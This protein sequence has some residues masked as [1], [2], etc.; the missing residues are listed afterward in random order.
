MRNGPFPLTALASLGLALV[1][2]WAGVLSLPEAAAA[3]LSLALAAWLSRRLSGFRR[4][5]LEL[6]LLPAAYVLT[7][8]READ[9]RQLLL[10]FLLS[11]ATL[12]A[13][14]LRP[15]ETWRAGEQALA[16]SVPLL[17]GLPLMASKFQMVDA[18]ALALPL[19]GAAAPQRL[20]LPGMLLSWALCSP[21][22]PGPLVGLLVGFLILRRHVAWWEKAG[23]VL[24]RWAVPLAAA[25]L[26]GAVLLPQGGLL[27][28]PTP[29][30]S[31]KAWLVLALGAVVTAFLPR[32]AA[33]LTWTGLLW[34]AL[35]LQPVPPDRPGPTLS[36]AKPQA[37][38]PAG[39][40]SLYTLEVGL[41]HAGSLPAGSPVATICVGE[42]RIVLR[43]GRET[44]EWAL[45]RADL[46]NRCAHGVP[47][48]PVFRPSREAPWAVAGRVRLF[49]PAQV[50]PLVVRDPTVPEEVVVTVLQA[51]P[52][53]P[54]PKRRVTGPVLLAIGSALA[55]LFLPGFL[56]HP[57]LAAPFALLAAGRLLLALPLQPLRILLERHGV[58]LALAGFLLAWALACRRF[59][60]QRRWAIPAL[61][62]LVPLS[63]LA[64]Q[65]SQ[66]MGDEP[67]HLALAESLAADGDLDVTNNVDLERYPLWV[68]E[69][70]RQA[71]GRFL[72]SPAL[73]LLLFP[74]YLLAGRTGM[75]VG[76]GLLAWL[77][78]LALERRAHQLSFSP[79]ARHLAL[80]LTVFS[81]PLALLATELWPEMPAVAAV[82]WQLLWAGGGSFWPSAGVA[83]LATLVKTR[84]GLVTVPLVAAA[85]AA[86]LS[87]RRARLLA[88]VAAAAV[89]VLALALAA[90][91]FGNP[92][93]PLGRRAISHLV[94]RDWHQP[95][96]VVFGLA[97]DSAY[98]LTFA[99]PLWLLGFVG[100]GG[101]WRRGGW[102]EKAA[103]GGAGCTVMALLSYVEWR[104]GGSPPFRYLVPL[105]PV[106]FLGLLVTLRRPWGRALA[107]VGLP[108]TLLVGWLALTRPAM[109]YNIGDG[110]HWLADRLAVRLAADVR[111]FFPSYLH[112][113]LASYLAPPL[114]VG[115]LAGGAWLL[116][117]R[118]RLRRTLSRQALAF[119]LVAG[120]SLLVTARM[121]PDRVVE[122]EAPQVVHQG[123]L[124]EPHPGAWS[125]FLYPNGWRL[126][127]GDELSVP[128]KLAAHCPLALVG[129]VEEGSGGGCRLAYRVEPAG[130]KGQLAVPA[131]WR[132]ELPLAAAGPGRVQLTLS[133]VCVGESTVVL[134]RLEAQW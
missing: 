38:L 62:W 17:A 121:L 13:V 26:A 7:L 130:P 64:P 11:L 22:H 41:A 115:L 105:L 69:L 94:P 27:A 1:L 3:G 33:A 91:W 31:W 12:A 28:L 116:A 15:S 80:A 98:G 83:V 52:E 20:L 120:S 78:L 18:L 97:F 55:A 25:G 128:L 21:A 42:E 87:S 111:R 106:V 51:G 129:W 72:H 10:Q 99:A 48:D 8:T 44:A 124:L 86:R 30:L 133:T 79:R 88:L 89:A 67:Y 109:L 65:L 96:R 82:S 35:P 19:V 107:L 126:G 92:L 68:V 122:L 100:V 117:R 57:W 125:R 29:P 2:P 81:Y 23:T 110:G 112:P 76:V 134:D 54:P 24:S 114:V 56:S 84:L 16:M 47:S 66:L 61:L 95:L 34:A 58:D 60:R 37:A 77:A 93:D 6:L 70:S 45:L 132:G 108:P 127:N 90:L 36:V 102:G 131:G 53:L 113:R 75:V 49:V 85:M 39:T 4:L 123:G 104:G 74:A 14:G 101:L 73:A 50:V 5:G 9:Q 32:A 40:G 118:P 43:A 103:I 59:F 71:G 119:W 63:L 46:K